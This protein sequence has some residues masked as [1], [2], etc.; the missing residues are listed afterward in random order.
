M[1]TKKEEK[2]KNHDGMIASFC[3]WPLVLTGND[4][5]LANERNDIKDSKAG[6]LQVDDSFEAKLVWF[7]PSRVAL[8]CPLLSLLAILVA[9]A[10]V[11]LVD[12]AEVHDEM[13]IPF[14]SDFGGYDPSR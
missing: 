1:P 7:Q 2:S 14:I 9:F 8:M 11:P 13:I 12:F 10:M 4:A 6:N 5:Y 3:S